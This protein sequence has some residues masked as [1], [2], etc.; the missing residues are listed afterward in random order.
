[1]QRASRR[2]AP[3]RSGSTRHGIA[4]RTWSAERRCWRRRRSLRGCSRQRAAADRRARRHRRSCGVS[5]RRGGTGR[6]ARTPAA[7]PP[8]RW[9]SAAP[10]LAR[11]LAWP[12]TPRCSARGR[13]RALVGGGA[14]L[15]VR[16]TRGVGMGDVKGRRRRSASSAATGARD[17][18]A[19]GGRRHRGRPLRRTGCSRGVDRAPARA[20][21][22]GSGWAVALLGDLDRDGG[23]E[24]E[25]ERAEQRPY[26]VAGTRGGAGGAGRRAGRVGAL[27]RRR[28]ACRWCSSSQRWR[29][30]SI[31]RRRSD[32]HRRRVR[33]AGAGPGAGGVAGRDWSAGSPRST[34]S[35]ARWCS[36]ACGETEPLLAV[37]RAERGRGAA[38][39]AA[40]R[41]GSAQ[42][43]AGV[44]A[45]LAPG[46]TPHV[47]GR[48]CV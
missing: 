41:R 6:R 1:M 8:A 25:S 17:R 14:V 5:A 38:G 43:D 10:S 45:P 32:R 31:H 20:C 28:N 47:A 37:G 19:R 3:R 39:R 16:L 34:C 46:A 24:D 30:V 36:R 4:R 13:R 26:P 21:R 12:A 48:G 15:V 42:G 40:A 2:G 18:R 23:H 35:R 9:V 29:R 22:C 7:E 44:A 27:A 11:P 33:R